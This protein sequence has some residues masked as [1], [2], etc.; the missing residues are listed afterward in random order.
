MSLDGSTQSF[1]PYT[2]NGVTDAGLGSTYVPY[3]GAS[4][5]VDLNS[6]T[7]RTTA[8]PVLSSDLTNKTYVD[9]AVA[10]LVPYTGAS[11]TV[12]LGA[13]SIRTTRV[14]T[15]TNELT[16]KT[17]VDTAISTSAAGLVP[18][19]G[20][21]GTV[22]LGAQ[23]IRTTRVPTLTN[24]LTNKT[25]VDTAVAARVPYTGA[26]SDV[27]LGAYSI[28]AATAQFSSVTAGTPTLALGLNG[29]GMLRSFAVPTST[30]SGSVSAGYVP[31]AS[32]SNVFANS[33][34]YQ[35]G[36]SVGIGTAAPAG[37]MTVYAT[38]AADADR[39]TTLV[40]N[41]Y[42]AGI[43][44]TSNGT[45]GCDWNQYV[46]TA[47]EAPPQDSIVWYNQGTSQFR[48]VLT[49]TGKLG[50]GTD[51]PPCKMYVYESAASGWAAQSYFGNSTTGVIAGTYANVA[52]I[53]GHN[54]ALNAWTNL[55]INAGGGNVGIATASPSW[56]LTVKSTG[57]GIM[58]AQ[59][60]GPQVG[61]YAGGGSAYIGT[62]SNHNLNFC[63][64][65][66]SPQMTIQASNGYVGIGTAS[67]SQ[68]LHVSG[69]GARVQVESNTTNNAVVQIKTNA[70]TSYLLTDQSGHIQLY[71]G[72][73]GLKTS[74]GN[75]ANYVGLGRTSAALCVVE[76]QTT[77]LTCASSF[78][79][80]PGPATTWF[81]VVF[82]TAP[83]HDTGQNP[84]KVCIARTTVHTDAYFRG[85][86][87][88]TFEGNSSVWGNGADYFSYEVS[89]ISAPPATYNYFVGNAYVDFTSG[90]LV[91]YLRG[92]TT[93]YYTTEGAQLI[94]YPSTSPFISY[95]IPAGT[96]T[97]LYSL[98]A[99][100]SPF[101]NTYAKLDSVQG[102]LTYNPSSY[103]ATNTFLTNLAGGG[104]KMKTS[105]GYGFATWYNANPGGAQYVNVVVGP[106]VT[107]YGP[108]SWSGTGYTLFAGT[109]EPGPTAS[110]LGI[111]GGNNGGYSTYGDNYITSLTPAIIWSNLWISAHQTLVRYDGVLAAYTV[112]GGWVNV[113]DAR[114]KEDILDL[115]TSRSLE[116]VLAVRPKTYR[117]K[118]YEG[119]TPS[120]EPDAQLIGFLAQDMLAINKHC[121]S[122]WRNDD[123]EKTDEDD[124][125]RYGIC[126][127]DWIVHLVGAV[128]EQQ[129]QIAEQQKQIAENGATIAEQ[130][131]HIETLSTRSKGLEDHA[132]ALE[133]EFAEYRSLTDARFDKLAVLLSGK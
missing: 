37:R 32:S 99:A 101:N 82:N 86:L 64:Y 71:P 83:A 54:G 110:C 51:S 103:A 119:S 131:G 11:G 29:S 26:T 76:S 55:A 16:N 72:T 3:S 67:P 43:R 85:S 49:Q 60:S 66:S 62:Y 21:S 129:K 48:M 42:R 122:T 38:S 22:D 109:L 65:N 87:V 18:Y 113:S 84:W 90:F 69:D 59:D 17:Y 7:I 56:P 108:S 27:T 30:F 100:V 74:I 39:L 12:D 34:L 52:Y 123:V 79:I 102:I 124:G 45:S 23:S 40:L 126:Y 44:M 132:R 92:G 98:G 120:F 91:V 95:T 35:S 61:F 75:N 20:A 8:T 63:T 114:E 46:T 13:Q 28:L 97:V 115:K 10:G 36:T 25:Y 121:L 1:I 24:E 130:K 57:W 9:T 107:D 125:T 53:G 15:L 81:P 33:L 77:T 111:G 106:G 127:N 41:T 58:C 50:I 2:L 5:T 4:G 80:V 117:R 78:Y 70:N 31:Y 116:R 93:Y 14:P 112:A 68:L 6:Q 105:N 19:T 47:G 118:K 73:A 88:A 104:V 94:Y 133:K 128:Q 96:G 89:G